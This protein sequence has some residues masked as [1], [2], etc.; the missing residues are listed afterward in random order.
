M[1][2]ALCLA[3]SQ[4]SWKRRSDC[5]AQ[6]WQEAQAQDKLDAYHAYVQEHPNGA[7]MADAELAI[8]NLGP[9]EGQLSIYYS[10]GGRRNTFSFE[11]AGREFELCLSDDTDFAEDEERVLSSGGRYEVTGRISEAWCPNTRV[12]PESIVGAITVRRIR[13]VDN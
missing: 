6:E 3:A 2:A 1:T 12:R 5:G 7:Y 4:R 11:I 13:R 10:A 9:D 8:A